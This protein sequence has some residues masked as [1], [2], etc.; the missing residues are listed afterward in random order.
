M[1]HSEKI[2][3]WTTNPQNK[4][5]LTKKL[6]SFLSLTIRKQQL[7][8]L[9]KAVNPTPHLAVADIGFSPTEDMVD[10]N[11]FEKHYPYQ[12]RITAVSVE[13]CTEIK[14]RYPLIKIIE[15]LPNSRFP[16]K[17]KQFDLSTSWATLEHVGG[18]KEQKYFLSELL[19]IGKKIFVTTPYRGCIY[20]PH[21]GLFFLHWL[22]LRIFRRICNLIGKSF[23]SSPTNFNPLYAKDVFRLIPD[24]KLKVIVFKMFGFLPSHLIITNINDST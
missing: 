2:S 8:I 12:D 21:T 18:Y 11:Y 19:R 7:Q 16:F 15:I 10:A 4:I 13:N 3:T 1:K 17:N 14:K 24:H 20:E 6:L 23:W 22:P 5:G 9:T